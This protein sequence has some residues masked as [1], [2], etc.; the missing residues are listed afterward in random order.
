MSYRL[1][2]SS[3]SFAALALAGCSEDVPT[4]VQTVQLAVVAGSDHGG[5]PFT[6]A[7]TQEVTHTPPYQ[8]DPDGSGTA[9]LSI[10]VGQGEVCWETS[11]ADISTATA[12]HIHHEVA[13]VRGPI[14]VVLSPPDANGT[15]QGC[16]TGAD[17]AL[18]RDILSNP[19]AYYV[20]V[21]T[22]T[23]PGGEIRGQLK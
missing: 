6:Q 8:G 5:R 21:H 4:D 23:F 14:V 11:V 16:N 15:A 19:E 1:A 10:N 17:P 2:L 7:M 12:S 20:N 13:G 18:L 3:L 22:P 9:L